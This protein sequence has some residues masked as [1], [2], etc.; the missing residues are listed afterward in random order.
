MPINLNITVRTIF[1]LLVASCQSAAALR[2]SLSEPCMVTDF[3]ALCRGTING[4]TNVN[5]A[6]DVAIRELMKR[7]RHARDIAKKE[8]RVLDGG[9]A[10][11]LS[12]FN[13]AFDNLD[14]ALKN[15]KENDG[16]SLNI[17]LSAALTDY[18]TCSE[19]MKGS[20]EINVVYKSAGVLYKMADNCLALS[21]LVKL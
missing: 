19:A 20:K 15:V 18:D 1:L 17:N 2:P 4:Q 6:T 21:T 13:S 10:T 8:L 9:V 14:K 3:P 11:C 5:A 12:N 7:T 16:F